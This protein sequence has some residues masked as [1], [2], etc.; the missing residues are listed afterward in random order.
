MFI[1]VDMSFKSA[2]QC[3]FSVLVLL[4]TTIVRA[5]T[6][7]VELSAGK[8]MLPSSDGYDI[9][10]KYTMQ[11]G[12]NREFTVSK[13]KELFVLGGIKYQNRFET[14]FSEKVYQVNL[15]TVKYENTLRYMLNYITVPV[16]VKKYFK[17][18][19][20]R[21]FATVGAN[22]QYFFSGVVFTKYYDPYKLLVENRVELYH[23]EELSNSVSL[24]PMASIGIE[25]GKFQYSITGMS[26]VYSGQTG[27]TNSILLNAAYL[28]PKKPKKDDQ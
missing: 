18:F 7:S 28:I 1:F 25:H 13:A 23:E 20:I 2:L 4:P 9:K 8:Y 21:S 16:Q 27:S 17:V 5:Q 19:G 26:N 6:W 22:F 12:T 3:C 24:G 14:H 10:G 11:L 15:N